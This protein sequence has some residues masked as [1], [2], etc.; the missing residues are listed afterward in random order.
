MAWPDPDPEKP[1]VCPAC[2]GELERGFCGFCMARAEI[3]QQC[4]KCLGNRIKWHCDRCNGTKLDPEPKGYI[5][6]K[7]GV[8]RKA[9]HEIQG[10][11]EGSRR[12]LRLHDRRGQ[13]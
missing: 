4:R 11:D 13:G 6:Y 12:L 7:V 10:N 3:V 2:E 1:T 9:Q 8:A 5:G